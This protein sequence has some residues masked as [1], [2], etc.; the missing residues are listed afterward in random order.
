ARY[1]LQID[2]VNE[3]I[4]SA[5]GGAA[6]TATIEGRN[7]F[8][9]NVRYAEE[10]RSSLQAIRE[11]A[12]PLPGATTA[13]PGQIALGTIADVHIV[14]GP[15]MIRDEVGML[16]GYVYVDIEPDRDMGSY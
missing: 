15:P 12:I 8:T 9:V 16:V 10:F 14:S 3:V 13:A 6:V 2:D 4:E 1:G 11:V 5:L 7:R